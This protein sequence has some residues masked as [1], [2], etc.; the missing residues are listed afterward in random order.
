MGIVIEAA[1]VT[2][3]CDSEDRNMFC[4]GFTTFD[5][6]PDGYMGAHGAAMQMGWLERQT[7][8]GRK[9]LCPT[10]SGKR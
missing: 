3:E 5:N 1:K 6:H 9:F 7:S 8:Q 10:C 4:R 2:F